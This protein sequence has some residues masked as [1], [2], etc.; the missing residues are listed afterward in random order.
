M[1][2]N[3]SANNVRLSG[4]SDSY[5]G[6]VAGNLGVGIAAPTAR[7]HLDTGTTT[8]APLKFVSGTNLTT[9]QAG[10]M[11]FNGTNLLFTPVAIRHTMNH[12]LVSSPSLNFS[13]GGNLAANTHRDIN[14]NLANAV[15]GDIVSI[16]VPH[17]AVIANTCYT[18]WVS[19]SGV[20]TV[21]LNNYSTSS[22]TPPAAQ[23]FKIFVT[24]ID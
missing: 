1:R 21:R 12:G 10:A 8:I 18:A 9:T 7:L 16:G 11:E 3:T 2:T 4:T 22:I 23:T 5:I 24:K 20:V 14:T 19:T 17:A 13:T 6:L 15:V